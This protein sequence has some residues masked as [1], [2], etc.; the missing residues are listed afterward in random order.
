M[1]REDGVTLVELAAVLGLLAAALSLALPALTEGLAAVEAHAAAADLH[2]ALHA[3]RARA[4]ATG[5]THGLRLEPGG[6]AFRVVEDPGGAAR[7][8]AGPTALAGA[9]TASANADV[10]FSPKGFAVPFGTITVRSGPA[11]RRLVVN[12]VGRVRVADGAG[13]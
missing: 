11:V 5:L 10:Q 7:T 1:R 2:A 4:R 6:R 3:T 8:V 12:L 13:P 9:A